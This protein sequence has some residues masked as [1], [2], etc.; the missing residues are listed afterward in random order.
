M[1]K[2]YKAHA[3]KTCMQLYGVASK[4]FSETSCYF[5]IFQK[6]VIIYVIH[7]NKIKYS[8]VWEKFAHN[9]FIKKPLLAIRVI[10]FKWYLLESHFRHR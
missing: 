4:V 2:F 3:S 10:C 9:L 8:L 7:V 6:Y 1:F 5:M